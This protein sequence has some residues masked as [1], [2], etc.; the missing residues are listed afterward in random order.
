MKAPTALQ[1]K[2]M[3]RVRRMP[4][5]VC[6]GQSTLH[7]VTAHADRM[8]RITRSHERVVPLCGVHHQIIWGPRESVEALGHRGFFQAYGIDLLAVADRLWAETNERKAA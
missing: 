3:D 1:K 2:H 7:H 5:L 4:C 6:G 8:G